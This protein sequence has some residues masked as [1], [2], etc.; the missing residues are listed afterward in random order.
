[1]S[2]GEDGS[3]RYTR[4]PMVVPATILDGRRKDEKDLFGTKLLPTNSCPSL[5]KPTD[6]G[7]A[8]TMTFKGQSGGDRP[9][10]REGIWDPVTVTENSK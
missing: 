5:N 4:I 7:Q 2:R 10:Q 1:M 9:T 8:P 6:L 3:L